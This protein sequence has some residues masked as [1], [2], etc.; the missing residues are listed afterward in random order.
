MR[1]TPAPQAQ[2][3]P[4]GALN[5]PVYISPIAVAFNLPGITELKLDATT[6][7]KIFRGEIANW[8]DPAIAALN[9]G[10]SLPDLKVTPV[11]R[12]DDSGTTTN[13]TEYLAAAAPGGLDRQ[14]CR[15]LARNPPGRKR[16]GHLRC[17]QDRHRHPGRRD[18]RG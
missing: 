3:G 6:V 15:H 17:G 4:E 8:N 12:S 7:A 14:G 2:C 18:L 11:N 13:F 10:V 1:S 9:P 16:Q 5:I